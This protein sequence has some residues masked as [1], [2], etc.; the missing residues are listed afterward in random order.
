[1]HPVGVYFSPKSRDYNP[2]GF[3]P[4]YRGQLIML[5]QSHR[6]FQVV[7]PRTLGQLHGQTL[8]LPNVSVISETE[9]TALRQ[10]AT[11]GGRIVIT[12]QNATNLPDS[13]QVIRLAECPST[14]Y[15]KSLQQDFPKASQ[16]LPTKFLES[17]QTSSE[18][19]VDASPTVAANFGQVGGVPHIFLANFGGLVPGKIA[20]PTT[21]RNIRV[22]IPAAA[23]N[24]LVFLPFL[25]ESQIVR[26]V[27]KGTQV[28]FALP[29]LERGAVVWVVT[30]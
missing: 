17:L 1:M 20:I 11:R 22:R 3:L 26:G 7:T 27:K 16:A 13:S 30:K 21:E 4:S 5:L 9:R 25:G 23:G 2:D 28:E 29:P 15:F 18:I 8:V 24:A 19:E 10:F 14:A 12:G 6:E